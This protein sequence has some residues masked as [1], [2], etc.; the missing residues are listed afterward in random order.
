VKTG[1]DVKIPLK[2]KAKEWPDFMEKNHKTVTYD[3]KTVLG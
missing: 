1:K 3:S 2:L